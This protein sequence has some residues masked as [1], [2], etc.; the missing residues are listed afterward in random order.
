[1]FHSSIH[2]NISFVSQV[3]RRPE[4]QPKKAAATSWTMDSPH[5]RQLPAHRQHHPGVV[6][7]AWATDPPR[8]LQGPH[9]CGLN[10]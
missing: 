8:A 2:P 5:H 7:P 4:Q 10:R 1:M 3:R 9:H 6:S